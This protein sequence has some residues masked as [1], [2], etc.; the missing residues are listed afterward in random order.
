MPALTVQNAEIK[1]ASVEIKTITISG[2]QVTLAV[3]RQLPIA[4]WYRM[5]E[6]LGPGWGTV[7]YHP[8]KRCTQDDSDHT[9][10]V[11]QLGT[12]LR[13]ARVNRPIFSADSIGRITPADTE[14]EIVRCPRLKE[15]A[16]VDISQDRTVVTFPDQGTF[17]P[18]LARVAM[19]AE[20]WTPRWTRDHECSE[21]CAA[22]LQRTL[23]SWSAEVLGD[24]SELDQWSQAWRLPQLFIAV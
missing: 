17:G 1:T 14:K 11:W 9:H 4:P 15:I 2:K 16:S 12:E 3:F 18:R 23:R 20:F 21:R 7:N 8:D 5:A 22:T 19:R 6:P 13:R 10:V 24:L